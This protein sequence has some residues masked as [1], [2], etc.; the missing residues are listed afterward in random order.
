MGFGFSGEDTLT[1]GTGTNKGFDILIG[2][3]GNDSYVLPSGRS[4]LIAELGGDAAD[5][6]TSTELTLNGANTKFGTLEGGRHLVISD[7]GTNTRAYLYDWQTN[8]NKIESFQLTDGTFSFLQLQ[9]KV[10][11]LGASVTDST[12]ASWDSQFGNNQLTNVGFASGT[13]VDKLLNFYNTVDA[14]GV[15]A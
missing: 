8:G 12:W 4:T 10:T 15:I 13:S 6:F 5:S 3:A 9:Q 14:S 7:S 2:G 11:S 1:G